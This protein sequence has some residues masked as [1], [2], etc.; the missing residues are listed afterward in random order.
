MDAKRHA[1]VSDLFAR[2]CE[3]GAEERK[4]LLEQVCA[5]DPELRAEVE[6][7]LAHDEKPAALLHT[8]EMH[9]RIRIL[10][11]SRP[12]SDQP[13]SRPTRIGAYKILRLLG[14]GG[15]GVV[16]AAEQQTPRRTVALKVLK[17]GVYA[18]PRGVR[19]FLREIQALAAL[20][21]PGIATIY[22]AGRTDD[23]QHFLAMELVAG[24]S[25]DT[26]VRE[27]QLALRECL[28]LFCKVCDAV[29]YA[30]ENGLIHRDLKPRNVLVTADGAP[31]ILDFG[32]VRMT[33]AD[34]TRASTDLGSGEIVGSLGYMSPEQA[35]GKNPELGV[36]SDVYS[37]GVILY[38]LVT[39]QRPYAVGNFLPDAVRTI[40]ETAPRRPGAINRALR[41]DLEAIA[42]KVLEKEPSRRY[43]SASEL[44]QDLRRYLRGEPVT[45]RRPSALYVLTKKVRKRPVVAALCALG[46]VLG[47]AS[48]NAWRCTRPNA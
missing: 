38:E 39:G 2:V 21:H 31:K 35:C 47:I 22:E 36:H 48:S 18:G 37:L 5:G 15:Q 7:L 33:H 42:L 30:H 19:H 4:A 9:E 13:D 41:G 20:S 27:N 40:C 17:G 44:A 45:A 32:L 24:E 11:D 43:Q 8:A 10:L 16:Y 1:R 6:S 34:Q 46:L 28:E 29:H 23:G 26:F 12:V 25:I 14:E 3:L